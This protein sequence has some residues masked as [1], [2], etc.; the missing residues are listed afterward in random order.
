[1]IFQV[2]VFWVVTFYR[3]VVGYQCFRDP[4]YLDLHGSM[5]PWNFGIPPQ[6]YTASQSRRPR[7]GVSRNVRNSKQ[8][9][10]VVYV[11]AM[12]IFANCLKS[13]SVAR[14]YT[15]SNNNKIIQ[16]LLS[17]YMTNFLVKSLK[18]R[19]VWKLLLHPI[20]SLLNPFQIL[21]NYLYN[22]QFN[23]ILVYAFRFYK[24]SPSKFYT[25]I[26]FL[27]QNYMPR[28][29]NYFDVTILTLLVEHYEKIQE[30]Q[31]DN[32]TLFFSKHWNMPCLWY[33]T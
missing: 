10:I 19:N 23:I 17:Y 11:M 9:V 5:D 7:L 27:W 4:H 21:T 32:V 33:N 31:R 12:Q 28:Y 3:L 8:E 29:D 1:M 6:N 30:I 20:L 13:I 14:I 22:V 15:G 26:L 18:D 25:N 24:Y 2:E 16:A